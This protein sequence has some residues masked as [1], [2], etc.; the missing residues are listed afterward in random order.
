MSCRIMP[1]R[2]AGRRI[3]GLFRAFTGIG[4]QLL[5]TIGFTA[6]TRD[7][8]GVDFHLGISR[9][10]R[11]VVEGQLGQR[12]DIFDGE[13]GQIVNEFVA[14]IAGHRDDFAIGIAGMVHEAS[15]TAVFLSVDHVRVDAFFDVVWVVLVD[16][17]IPVQREQVGMSVFPRGSFLAPSGGFAGDDFAEVAVDELAS[18]DQVERAKA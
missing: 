7:S 11:V 12:R 8:I 9:P 10:V 3:D 17:I 4:P 14:V 6:K 5:P 16:L 15:W 13:E 18:P 1:V 2:Q